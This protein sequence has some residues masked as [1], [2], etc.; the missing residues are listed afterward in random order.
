[1]ANFDTD[2]D[3]VDFGMPKV[4]IGTEIRATIRYTEKPYL[5]LVDEL[6]PQVHQKV[7]AFIGEEQIK[8]LD[9]YDD[10]VTFSPADGPLVLS[11]LRA[12]GLNVNQQMAASAQE[13]VED[14]PGMATA[15]AKGVKV[16]ASEPARQQSQ[17]EID[18]E[19]RFFL[20][21]IKAKDV[22]IRRTGEVR[23]TWLHPVDL[24][25]G[26]T[27]SDL[28]WEIRQQ[29]AQIQIGTFD[30]KPFYQ[31]IQGPFDVAKLRKAYKKLLKD[32]TE[33][34]EG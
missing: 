21:G 34:A 18:K 5:V 30:I 33:D 28:R 17:R 10:A 29:G 9:V 6:P 20:N 8:P 15:A 12:I 3:L 7:L 1:M 2:A 27:G 23:Y 32:A 4:G 13:P 14:V 11:F 22:H 24:D 16:E 25:I 31:I 26:D 19:V